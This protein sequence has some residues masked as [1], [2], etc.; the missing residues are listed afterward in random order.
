MSRDMYRDLS[1]LPRMPDDFAAQ[2]RSAANAGQPIGERIQSLASYALDEN[3]LTRLA[4]LIAET[5]AQG[6]P[7]APLIPFRLAVVSNATTHFAVPALIGTAARHG[8][9]L[10]CIEADFGQAVQEALTPDSAINRARPDAVLV[11]LDHRGL[12]LRPSP[13]DR[14]A[15][16]ATVAAC[17]AQLNAI[18]DGIHRH[19]NALCLLQTIA[20]P[21]EAT[22]GSLDFALPGT[23]R[24]LV[25]A[26]NRGMAESLAGSSDLLFDVAGIAET[27]GLADWHE[28]KL[29]NLAKIPF[30]NIFLPIYAEH[31][32]RLVAAIRG[33]SRR[34]LVL[35]LDN[36]L[37]GGV[38]GD[39]GLDGIVI[40]QGDATG[41]AHLHL[42]QTALHLRDRGVVLAVSSKNN[43]RTARLPFQRHPEMLMKEE[44]FAVFQANWN[45]KA[46]NIIA[47][48]QELSLGIDALVFLDDNPVERDLVRRFLPAV[49]VPELP[50]DPAL[51]ARTLCAAGHFEAIAFSL[52]DRRRA[53]F[54]QANARRIALQGQSG[55]VDAY[56]ES[57]DMVITFQPFDDTG[58]SRIT[59]LI[60]KSNQFN[61]TT[62]RYTEAE[63]QAA[64]AAPE[65]FTL[66]VRLADAFGDNG[67]ISVVIC[68]ETERDW[69][70]DT[71]LMSC[72]VLGRKVE[73]AVLQEILYHARRQGIR[74]IIGHYRPT[75][76]NALVADHYP[77]LGFTALRQADGGRTTWQLDVAT[78][79][80]HAVPMQVRRSG[81]AIQ[82]A[83]EIADAR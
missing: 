31:A 63:V 52:E 4:R 21:P 38:I 43:D 17:L 22:F 56:L 53:D 61:L 19:C 47:I 45:N 33:R 67:M 14:D 27:V 36:T 28:P 55:D 76:R 60:N 37:W 81:F 29:W 65:C 23:M 71:W 5:M 58:R 49:A 69:E 10:E 6:M 48:A 3:A 57:L 11:A 79:P 26:V 12:P 1:W 46:A 62:K 13:G 70:V 82:D 25:E 80:L 30:S 32:C 64:Q 75:D 35:D 51:F 59:Q 39:D 74:R 8:I 77:N 66:Q 40:G 34:C 68:R 44:H 9:A 41:E 72:R 18:R 2:C 73:A 54:Y 24:S 20:R 83:D 7:L 78:A 15:A 42:Q 16:T 50:A